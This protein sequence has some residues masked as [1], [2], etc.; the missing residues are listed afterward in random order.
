MA[1]EVLIIWPQTGEA[2]K[3]HDAILR[4]DLGIHPRLLT[5]YPDRAQLAAL[6][7]GSDIVKA[8]VVGM[9]FHDRALQVLRDLNADANQVLTVAAHTS[10]SADVLRAVMRAGAS[11]FLA[12]PFSVPDIRRC[13]EPIAARSDERPEGTLIAMMPAQGADGAST[14]ALHVAHE[15]SESL[16]R[17]PLL[18]D[19]DVQCGVAAFRLGQQ[20]KY[21][22]ADALAHV[23]R[24]DELLPKIVVRWRGFDLV[25]APDTPLGLMGDHMDRL[26]R[27]LAVARRHYPV[28]IAD[29]PPGLFTSGLSVLLDADEIHLVCT[30]EI[31]SLHLG[32]RRLNELVEYGVGKDRLRVL[33]NRSDSRNPISPKDI[34]RVI[35]APIY[36]ELANDYQAVTAAAV[37][38]GLVAEESGFGRS[39]R[40]LATRISG[41]TPAEARRHSGGWKRILRFS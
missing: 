29:L 21:T 27:A 26:P 25:V 34:E 18:V 32:R 24:L 15:L 4:S 35:G 41:I 37:E 28:V 22:L 3:L 17:A 36:Q 30:P 2:A 8:V 10:E 20:P 19:C 33:L 13:L 7:A 9:T 39:L 14:I 1:T 11:D 6:L 31:T 23:D 38:G 12:P 5:A 40:Q 16:G